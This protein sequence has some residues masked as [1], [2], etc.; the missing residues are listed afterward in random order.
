M[1]IILSTDREPAQLMENSRAAW[2]SRKLGLKAKTAAMCILQDNLDIEDKHVPEACLEGL[3]ILGPASQSN[4]FEPF[5]C[6]PNMSEEEF[7]SGL[8]VRSEEM[9]KRVEKM[10]KLGGKELSVAI[11]EKTQKEVEKGTMSRPMSLSELRHEYGDDFQVVPSFGLAQG[12]DERGQKKFR[13]IDDHTAS[14]ANRVALRKQKAPMTMIDYVAVLVRELAARGV[15]D[16]NL[17]SDDMKSAYRQIPLSP[18]D[19]RYAITGVWNPHKE[20]VEL[21]HMHG[22]PFGAG[23]AVPN[24]CRVAEWIS[25][26]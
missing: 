24:F 6:I 8:R 20:Q 15:Q 14:G 19:V 16:I 21:Y 18:R 11:W 10:A 2:T 26:E 17:A 12:L 23:H 9:V 1:E 5:E 13:R 25:R 7:Y 22:Q 4:F 3:R